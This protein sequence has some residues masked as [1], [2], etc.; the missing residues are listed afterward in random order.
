M[1]FANK[2]GNLDEIDMLFKTFYKEMKNLK[3]LQISY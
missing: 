2:F 3:I 1:L